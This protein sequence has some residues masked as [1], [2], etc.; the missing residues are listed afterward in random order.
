MYKHNS[1]ADRDL[2]ITEMEE[3]IKYRQKLLLEKKQQLEDRKKENH[4][5]EGVINDY[6][7]YYDYIITE[8]K[9]QIQSMV[10]LN[11]YLEN[12]V[13]TDKMT[14]QEIQDAKN[15]QKNILKELNKIKDELDSLV[16]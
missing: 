6:Q 2:K 15:E 13:K 16:S 14:K 12:L 7:K 8:K 9:Q 11:T 10:I 1:L 4:F 5:L 3:Q